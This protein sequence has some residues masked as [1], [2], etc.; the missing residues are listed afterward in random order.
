M[1]QCYHNKNKLKTNKIKCGVLKKYK[2]KQNKI[3]LERRGNGE[4]TEPG[5]CKVT[6]VRKRVF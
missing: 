5:E 4:D 1:N 2:T 3:Y 6:K